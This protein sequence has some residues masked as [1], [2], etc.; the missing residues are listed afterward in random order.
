MNGYSK[1]I[2]DT[3]LLT[4]QRKS[5]EALNAMQAAEHRKQQAISRRKKIEQLLAEYADRLCSLQSENHSTAE[6][7]NYRQFIAQLQDINQRT[8]HEINQ[9]I[10]A[11]EK[12][13]KHLL[14]AE[15]ERLKQQKLVQR[16]T[17]RRDKI[18]HIA[19]TKATD[20]QSMIQFNIKSKTQ[21]QR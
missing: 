17:N 12:T 7:I 11:C 13:K 3:L 15:Q 10:T 9:A 8:S 16:E 18:Q 19:E 20:A 14:V 21:Q 2:W 5:G 6:A 4:A 1:S